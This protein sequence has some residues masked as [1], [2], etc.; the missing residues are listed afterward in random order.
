MTVSPESRQSFARFVEAAISKGGAWRK[1]RCNRCSQ[2][3]VRMDRPACESGVRFPIHKPRA[4]ISV[5]ARE[6]ES[7]LQSSDVA[8]FLLLLL[9]LRIASHL[10]FRFPLPNC[11]QG[12]NWP[13]VAS[14]VAAEVRWEAPR[15]EPNRAR[16]ERAVMG[17]TSSSCDRTYIFV[18]VVQ[19]DSC[20][21]SLLFDRYCQSCFQIFKYI[22]D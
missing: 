3:A 21:S 4:R 17:E 12:Q 13:T 7:S 2:P 14:K 20:L 19:Q 6:R 8:L 5:A 22:S 18:V 11:C 9:M 1:E 15:E 16:E 10:T